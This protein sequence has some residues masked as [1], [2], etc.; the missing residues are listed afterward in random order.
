MR[1]RRELVKQASNRFVHFTVGC[2]ENFRIA[3][4]SVGNKQKQTT[5][6]HKG[7]TAHSYFDVTGLNEKFDLLMTSN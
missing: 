3:V 7:S 2:G 4:T 5:P 1:A 6:P